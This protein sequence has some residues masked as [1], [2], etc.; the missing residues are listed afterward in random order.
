MN[1]L[2]ESVLVVEDDAAL[3]EA[4]TDTLRAAGITALPAS[5]AGEALELLESQ[6]IALVISDVQMPGANG[7]EL[8]SAIKRLICRSC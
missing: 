3:R 5:D 6:E 8:L 7:Y 2:N 1:K 4:L